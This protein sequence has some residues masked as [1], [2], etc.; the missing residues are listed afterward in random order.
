VALTFDDGPSP[1][2][3]QISAA[4]EAHDCRMYGQRYREFL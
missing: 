4:L 1:W 2:T 3:L